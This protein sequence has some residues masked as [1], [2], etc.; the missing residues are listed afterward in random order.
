MLVCVCGEIRDIVVLVVVVV[1][2]GGFLPFPIL[3]AI[4]MVFTIYFA[5]CL[6]L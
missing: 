4:M 3:F 2:G 5:L 6:P 1:V